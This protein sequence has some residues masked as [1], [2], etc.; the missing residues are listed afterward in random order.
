[1][2]NHYD[3]NWLI[4]KYENGDNLKFIY[5]WGNTNKNVN[6][7]D[8]SCFSQWYKSPFEV[9]NIIYETA[10]HWMMAQK[11]LL[12]NDQKAF[13]KITNCRKPGEAKE[14]G[15]TILGFYEQIWDERKFEIVKIGNIHKFN[16]YPKLA[17]YLYKT[18]ERILVEAS[19][20]D[21][22]W[23]VGLAHDNPNIENIYMWRGEN[24][25]GFALMEVRDFLSIFHRFD[26]IPNSLLPPWMKFMEVAKEDVFWRMGNGEDY[27]TN[28]AEFFLNLSSREQEIYK[29]TYPQPYSWK[30]FYD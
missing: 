17:E 22:I 29:L 23:G 2:R 26:A 4:D 25:L 11:A 9:A 30:G 28:F 24:L 13:A 6:E 5:F 16:Q 1:M 12:F 21:A 18:G 14:I 20:V 19:P 8:K 27:L 10:E 7:I 15:R 3:I